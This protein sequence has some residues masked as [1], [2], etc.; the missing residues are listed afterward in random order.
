LQK[1][2]VVVRRLLARL[3]GDWHSRGLAATALR[4]R[5]R[6]AR[7]GVGSGMA[8]QRVV[9]GAVAM[10]VLAASVVG[11]NPVHTAQG[12]TGNV[13]GAGS[14]VRLAI[15]GGSGSPN[16]TIT[17]LSGEA[18]P[19]NPAGGDAPGTA[20]GG[21]SGQTTGTGPAA[22][23]PGSEDIEAFS[24]SPGSGPDS[25]AA[26]IDA[27]SSAPVESTDQ[28]PFLADGTILK[29]IA[30]ETTAPDA[31]T[32]LTTYRVRKGDTLTSIA[33]H[34]GLSLVTL[35]WAN[36]LTTNLN[37]G[38]DLKVGRKLSI[39]PVNGVLHI[40]TDKETLTDIARRTGVS[41]ARIVAANG[42]KQPT[43]FVGQWI[44]IPGAKAK[45]MP[46]A[47]V[48]PKARVA[49]SAIKPKP[50]QR[51]TTSG[52]AWVWPAPGG[53]ISQYYH[54]GHWAIDIAGDYGA[55]V[56][57][58]HAGTV[59]FAGWRNNG[60]GWQVWI[61]NGNG[62]YTTYNHMSA[63]T[64]GT[65]QV[66]SAGHQVGRLGMTGHATGPHLHFEVWVGAIWDG[67]YRANPLN[68]V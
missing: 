6:I 55:P 65:G 8:Q 38:T 26:A 29:P 17:G 61:S 2:T 43:V 20:N 53:Y 35:Y 24:D 33:H 67:G 16:P 40:V 49:S 10:L 36:H 19:A 37:S 42:L 63:L 31:R 5:L 13:L 34:F 60:G 12:G 3:T 18:P 45:P 9:A 1:A 32:L 51:G 56:L 66:V 62:I 57:A 30:V 21:S 11:V 47:K 15:G 28:G 64:V 4:E 54:Y 46:V 44:I 41:A 58:A 52:G 39:P 27:Q 59:I 14:A 48:A 50:V 25:L 23:G 68:Y 7:S 22:S